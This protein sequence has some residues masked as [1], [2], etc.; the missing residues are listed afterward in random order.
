MQRNSERRTEGF[1]HKIL[2]RP[3]SERWA[4]CPAPLSDRKKPGGIKR[5]FRPG[6]LGVEGVGIGLQ[7]INT[8]A[9][10]STNDGTGDGASTAT[11]VLDYL[12]EDGFDGP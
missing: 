1:A 8:I 7:T 11:T 12:F 6:R 4:D 9:I 5:Q 3:H 10:T 2:D